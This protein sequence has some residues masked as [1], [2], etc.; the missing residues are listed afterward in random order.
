MTHAEKLVLSLERRIRE[1]YQQ[2]GETGFTEI[3]EAAPGATVDM[4]V[5]FSAV[6]DD[7][8]IEG[9]AVRW[10]VVDSYRTEFAPTAFANVR[11]SIPMLWSHDASNV[12]GSWSSIE[13]R[14]DG[15]TVRGKLNLAVAKAQEVRSLLQAKDVSGLS[16]GFR[17]LKDERRS[18]GVRRI[19]EARLHEISIV[20]F[21]SIPGSGVTHIRET[22]R[23]QSAAAFV[24]SCRKA[25]LALKGN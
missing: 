1:Y 18:N 2:S 15:L 7:G 13:A 4:E 3:R 19:T 16:V 9:R 20:A 23:D 21:P 22:G 5:R 12:I 14:D 10:D 17:T 25:A 24:A 6:G 8:T 11:G